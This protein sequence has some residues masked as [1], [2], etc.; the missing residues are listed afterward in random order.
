MNIEYVPI[1]EVKP[2]SK[3]AKK[4][5]KSQ[6]EKIA[7]SIEKFGWKQNLVIDKDGVLVVGHGRYEAAK[8]L[9]LKEVPC[10]RADDLTEDEVRAYRLIDNRISEGEYD[11]NVDEIK[12]MDM[13][14]DERKAAYSQL[15]TLTENQLKAESQ[16]RGAY[17]A[18][19]G[20]ARFDRQAIQRN[21]S[22]ALSASDEV[23]SFMDGLRRSQE[24]KTKEREQKAFS[25]AA[26]KA[27]KNGDLS[28]TVNGETWVRK[29]RRGNNF[30][31]QR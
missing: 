4:H 18:G 30:R 17:A 6:I 5:P 1:D 3:N 29:T 11:K 31:L 23:R 22:K 12:G 20:P 25:D 13:T 2:Y 8:L 14:A 26:M 21:Q 15:H 9:G 16:A 19:M 10:V 7:K 28:F 27:I 24:K